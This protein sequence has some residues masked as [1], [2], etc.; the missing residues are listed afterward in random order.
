MNYNNK[1][2]KIAIK[3]R[4]NTISSKTFM[5]IYFSLRKIYICLKLFCKLFLL[6]NY[7]FFIT[8]LCFFPVP[9]Y[10]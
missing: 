7:I 2:N 1:V 9:C 6:Y 10:K 3:Y 8:K 5:I 4:F